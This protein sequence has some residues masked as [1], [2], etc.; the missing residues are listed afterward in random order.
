MVSCI[1]H[2][3]A[4]MSSNRLR[5]NPSKTE[6]IW[7]G[8]SRRLHHCPADKVKISDA[9][10][11][12]TESVRDLGV[13]IDSAMTLTT[14]VNHLV[15]VCFFHL[16]QI[17]II[18]RSLSTDA[19]HSLVRALIHARVDYFNG[20][21]ASCLKYLTE[22]LQSVL[23]AAARLVLQLPYRSS[24]TDLLHRQLHIGLTFAVG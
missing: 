16:R 4:W 5:L 12:P 19:A 13:L 8:S 14:H 24:V 15:G 21:L 9:E 1:E 10:I 6:L 7:L 18:R 2:V 23:R 20:L 11:Q 3:N 17:R 22:K